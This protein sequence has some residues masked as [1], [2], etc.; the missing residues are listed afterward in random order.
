MNFNKLNRFELRIHRD[1][2]VYESYCIEINLE[3]LKPLAEVEDEFRS[4]IHAID[5]RCKPLKKLTKD[6]QFKVLLHTESYNFN[7]PKRDQDFLWIKDVHAAESSKGGEIIPL[8]IMSTDN[9]L[10]CY[11]EK[12]R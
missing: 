12:F 6:C 11:V 3:V 1:D 7:D 10:K 9:L 4:T 5:N 8:S 2:R